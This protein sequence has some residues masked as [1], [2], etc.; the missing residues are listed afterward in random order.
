MRLSIREIKKRK[1]R[2]W[3]RYF[4]LIPTKVG[5]EW[6]WLEWVERHMRHDVPHKWRRSAIVWEYR[7]I[8]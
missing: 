8:A 4:V 6:V 3:H 2:G 5:T 7:N 1:Q